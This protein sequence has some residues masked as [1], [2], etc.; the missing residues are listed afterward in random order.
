MRSVFNGGPYSVRRAR[1]SEYVA[2][3][4]GRFRAP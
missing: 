3:A 2:Y 4:A 1:S